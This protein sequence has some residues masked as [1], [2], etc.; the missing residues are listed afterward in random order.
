MEW[1]IKAMSNKAV[2]KKPSTH[3][4]ISEEKHL[5][6]CKSCQQVW[7][8]TWARSYLFYRHLPTYG[9]PRKT[10]KYCK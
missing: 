3:Y 2:P 10:C 5:S 6:Y 7:E 1:V 8:K 4:K 9:L